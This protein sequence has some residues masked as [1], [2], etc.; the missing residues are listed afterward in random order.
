MQGQSG[1]N[2]RNY[3]SYMMLQLSTTPQTG[4]SALRTAVGYGILQS[5]FLHTG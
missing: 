2:A 3:L 5:T 4:Y 1:A